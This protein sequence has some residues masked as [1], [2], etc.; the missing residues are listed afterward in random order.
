MFKRA[1]GRYAGRKVVDIL[2][3][4]PVVQ[5]ELNTVSSEIGS[6]AEQT[7]LRHRKTGMS[8]ISI[9]TGD[10]SDRF[11]ILTDEGGAAWAIERGRTGST[12]VG[13]LRDG[14]ASVAL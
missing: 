13:A 2:G 1:Q 4:M 9:R 5:S 11:V 12:P 10:K 14:I 6:V 7:M 8:K 3:K